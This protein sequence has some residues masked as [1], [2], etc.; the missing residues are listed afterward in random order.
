MGGGNN[1]QEKEK[2]KVIGNVYLCLTH[3]WHGTCMALMA[4]SSFDFV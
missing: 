4:K 3:V 2:H 1:V